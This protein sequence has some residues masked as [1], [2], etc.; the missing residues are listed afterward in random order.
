MRAK[1]FSQW[2]AVIVIGIANDLSELIFCRPA[3]R[4]FRGLGDLTRIRFRFG[5]VQC[6]WL[7]LDAIPF[8]TK[9]LL[10]RVDDAWCETRLLSWRVSLFVITAVLCFRAFHPLA[11]LSLADLC[12]HLFDL[13]FLS[14]F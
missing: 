6:S 11:L 4:V 5:A 10:I 14:C 13:G 9:N 3:G 8:G 1:S 2:I 12:D 7:G